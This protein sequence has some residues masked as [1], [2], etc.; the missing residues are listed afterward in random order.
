MGLFP[1]LFLYF[2]LDNTTQTLL[3]K[4]NELTSAKPYKAFLYDCDGTLADNMGAHKAA[5]RD[6]AEKHGIALDLALIDELA[7]W[8]TVL[9]A[10]EISKRYGISFDPV[11]FAEAKSARFIDHYLS[12]TQPISFVVEHLKQNS[13]HVGIAVVSGGR[14]STVSKTLEVLDIGSY[15]DVIVCAGE[16][17]RGKPH[18]DPFLK[19]A[20]LLGVEPSEC[21]VFEDGQPGVDGAIAAGMDWIRVDQLAKN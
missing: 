8:P 16:T 21:V 11:A 2:T 6:I 15:L 14:R 4:L 1:P 18:P 9:V 10:E 20:T 7:G 13:P 19:A 3:V 5:Y 17:P 12:S